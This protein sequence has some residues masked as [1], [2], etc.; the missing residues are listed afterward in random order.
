M[1]LS[2]LTNHNFAAA[3]NAVP[4]TEIVAVF[5][6]GDET[7]AEFVAFW[8]DTWGDIPA[9]GDYEQ[10][11]SEVNP[12]LI[13][14]AT[15]QT[16]HADQIE[17]AVASG[18]RGILCDKPLATSLREMDRIIAACENVPLA[19]GLDRR[20][21]LPFLHLRE[22]MEENVGSI[23]AAVAFG[24]NNTIN[25]GCH[26]YDSLLGLLG[27]P[28]PVWVSGLV[29]DSDSGN[30]RQGVD[31]S[32]RAQV[33]FDNGLVA[34]ITMDGGKGYSFEIVGDKGRISIPADG[35]EAYLRSANTNGIE[36]LALPEKEGRWPEGP[37][38]VR[39]LA[40]AVRSGQRTACDTEHARR[41]TEIGF[42]IHHSSNN[43]GARVMV[44]EVERSLRIPSYPWGNEKPV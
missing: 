21:S 37:A 20:W 22:T 8:R 14:V 6:H 7:R 44:S 2:D 32:S 26:L 41:A 36:A 34:Y 10:M 3:F 35:D 18:V 5:D 30:P 27:D 23:T 29:D 9:Y 33:G 38:I 31:P 43:G 13:C 11:L 39:D 42:A 28:D 24:L 17:A 19:F 12:D 1:L 25:H 40:N 16:M 15:R 4:D